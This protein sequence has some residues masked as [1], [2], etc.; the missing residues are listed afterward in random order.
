[1]ISYCEAADWHWAVAFN[2]RI[3]NQPELD[4]HG[5]IAGPT[6]DRF[7]ISLLPKAN[8]PTAC[9]ALRPIAILLA[10]AKLWSRC[11][12][13][14]L[15][16]YDVQCSPSHLGLRRGHSCA[17]LVTTVRLLLEKRSEW[18]QRTCLCKSTLLVLTT[19]SCMQPS[20]TQWAGGMY[21]GHCRSPTFA[22]RALMVL[23]HA[24]WETSPIRAGIGLRQGCSASPLVFRW[25]LQDCL[26][27]LHNTWAES[28]RG[29]R[30]EEET[31]AHLAWA[32]DTWLF[33]DTPASA[34]IMLSELESRATRE[35][36]LLIRCDT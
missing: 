15:G 24:S 31:L 21:P 23:R 30:V 14:I 16:E 22:R 7:D 32:D 13:S 6:W 35:T 27:P 26:M 12:F 25:V 33:S 10:S 18:K 5:N 36:G 11:F 2:M 17:E 8:A 4:S 28:G 20:S 3:M 34:D 1:M 19:A 29:I 9:K